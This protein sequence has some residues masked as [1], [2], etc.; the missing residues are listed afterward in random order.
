MCFRFPD[1]FDPADDD[2]GILDALVRQF[3]E[4]M[5]WLHIVFLQDAIILHG[6]C[7]S[8]P[9]WQHEVFSLPDWKNFTDDVARVHIE[10]DI[11]RDI[12]LAV[13]ILHVGEA[14]DAGCYAVWKATEQTIVNINWKQDKT[15]QEL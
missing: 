2:L 6:T 8:S 4:L 13:A 9:L 12:V 5:N 1:G 10:A 11:P 14:I 7:P 3:L 15:L